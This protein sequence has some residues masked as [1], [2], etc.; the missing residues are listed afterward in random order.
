[1]GTAEEAG[2]PGGAEGVAFLPEI[3]MTRLDC[4]KGA[5]RTFC[6][7]TFGGCPKVFAVSLSEALGEIGFDT[8]GDTCSSLGFAKAFSIFGTDIRD[9]LSPPWAGEEVPE[10]DVGALR[11][12]DLI[13]MGEVTE[14]SCWVPEP[15]PSVLLIRK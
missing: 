13:A 11:P 4:V 7:S 12:F 2:L 5:G 3:G 15:L 9:V 6:A 14:R 1:M 10:I 8:P